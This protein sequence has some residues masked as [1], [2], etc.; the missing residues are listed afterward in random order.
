MSE[1]Q[2]YG[3]VFPN[4]EQSCP[5]EILKQQASLEVSYLDFD[6]ATHSGIIEVN[7]RVADDVRAFFEQALAL[8]FPIGMVAPASDISY[9]WN[10]DRLMEANVSSGFNYRLI[11]G[12]DT[13]SLHGS[14]QAFD[15]NP[16]QN[17]YIRYEYNQEIVAPIGAVWQPTE[18]GTLSAQHPLVEFMI[19]R[20]WEWGGNWS[21]ESGRVD[22]QHFQKRLE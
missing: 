4:P 16:R 19:E 20:G 21:A 9:K 10:D 22:Y 15:I 17:P 13:P 8:N 6:G 18:P 11:A 5:P 2:K 1:N 3:G 12:T 7:E 14:G